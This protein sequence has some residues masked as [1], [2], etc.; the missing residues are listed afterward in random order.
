L[1]TFAALLADAAHAGDRRTVAYRATGN[2]AQYVPEVGPW[3]RKRTHRLPELDAG[4]ALGTF[5][6]RTLMARI[7]MAPRF[8]CFLGRQHCAW[9][10]P[11]F[12][13]MPRRS[14]RRFRPMEQ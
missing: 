11:W 1:H 13:W 10:I 2:P 14:T 4:P 12:A 8:I 9:L 7:R 6:R 3:I 5:S